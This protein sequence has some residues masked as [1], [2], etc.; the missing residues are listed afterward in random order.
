MSA[1]GD[2]GILYHI[3]KHTVVSNQI[4]GATCYTFNFQQFLDGGYVK[5]DGSANQILDLKDYPTSMVTSKYSDN[6][7]YISSPQ[8]PIMEFFGMAMFNWDVEGQTL[9]SA[10]FGD[11]TPVEIAEST[12]GKFPGGVTTSPGN[13]Y[14]LYLITQRSGG[15]ENSRHAK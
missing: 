7:Y 8:N 3:V 2:Y 9:W 12:D 10:D 5:P 13:N 11:N 14:L 6:F 1:D 4:S 15:D